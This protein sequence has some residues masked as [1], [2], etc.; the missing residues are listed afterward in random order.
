MP[1]ETK[2]YFLVLIAAIVSGFSIFLNSFAVSGI[3]AFVF[4]ALKNTVAAVF[5]FSLVLLFKDF[6][7]LKS[8]SKKAWA[9]L[10]LI[11]LIGGSIPFLLFFYALQLT[12]AV[13]AGL[14][15]KT[16]F[17]FASLFALVFLKE[18]LSRN[19]LIAAALLLIGNFLLFSS[20]SFFAL[21]DLLVL[22]AVVFW[23]AE[24]VLSKHALKELSGSTVAFGRM[25]FGSLF[26]LFF[27]A[28]SS[29]MNF[30]A[31]LSPVQFQWIILTS[32]PL[33]LFVIAFYS[34]LKTVPVS[35]ATA[36]LMIGQPVTL[37]LSLFFL[38]RALSFNEAIGILLTLIAIIALFASYFSIAFLKARGFFLAARN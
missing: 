35:K 12:S 19:F 21:P 27:L 33:F 28:L 15:H 14:L 23:A 3:N 5:L 13:N 20:V 38:G 11:G 1:L 30:I 31:E 18:K 4:T 10:C 32:I 34:G 17:V 2:A 9:K 25:F 16:I 24:N 8:L 29:Q 7:A 22:I 26:L 36:M 37:M 6:R